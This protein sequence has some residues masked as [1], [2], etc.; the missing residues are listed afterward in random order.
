MRKVVPERLTRMGIILNCCKN[1]YPGLFSSKRH[2]ACAREQIQSNH[3]Y[4][5]RFRMDKIAG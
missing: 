3:Y 5:L 4:P 1:F 2:S